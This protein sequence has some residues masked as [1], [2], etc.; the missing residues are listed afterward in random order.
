L[1]N[2]ENIEKLCFTL[3][4]GGNICIATDIFDYKNQITDIFERMNIF[5][6]VKFNLLNKNTQWFLEKNTKYEERAI[7]QGRTPCYLVYKKIRDC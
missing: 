3:K 6:R 7:C 5:E 4:R 2:R 1:L